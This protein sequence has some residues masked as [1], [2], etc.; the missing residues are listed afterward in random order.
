M[1]NKEEEISK[2]LFDLWEGYFFQAFTEPDF[3]LKKIYEFQEKQSAKFQD[4]NIDEK[5]KNNS[6]TTMA[7]SESSTDEISEL[8]N[9]LAKLEEQLS[10]LKNK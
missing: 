1:S 10:N 6:K 7:S 4:V 8:E 5:K 9:S 2:R 3:F